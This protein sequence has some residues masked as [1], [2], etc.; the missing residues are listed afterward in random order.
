MQQKMSLVL[1]YEFEIVFR[2][3]PPAEAG[4][5][6]CAIYGY[7]QRN[8]T[9]DFADNQMLK[10]AWETHIKPKIDENR[11][12]YNAI[13]EA[14]RNAGSKGGKATQEKQKQSNQA[15]A[16]FDLNNQPNQAKASDYDCDCDC[17]CDCELDIKENSLKEKT[18]S[19][20]AEGMEVIKLYEERFGVVS[21]YRATQL[22]DL[23]QD[24]GKDAVAYAVRQANVSSSTSIQYIRTTAMNYV[25]RLEDGRTV[26]PISTEPHYGKGTVL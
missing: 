6:I 3:L 21:S 19:F 20:S 4:R 16:S 7:E 25:R 5:L 9:P 2:S 13:C 12:K 24:F 8:E 17:D 14:R 15:N 1:P 10:F 11:E 18:K 23:V 22:D 26:K